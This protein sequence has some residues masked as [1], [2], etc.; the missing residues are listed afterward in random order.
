MFFP[1]IWLIFW[2]TKLCIIQGQNFEKS[3][4]LVKDS[5][6]ARALVVISVARR[7][8]KRSCRGFETRVL[9]LMGVRERA[10]AA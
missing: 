2:S 4:T 7:Q 9:D 3:V 6:S 5:Y 1:P 8:R 10:C